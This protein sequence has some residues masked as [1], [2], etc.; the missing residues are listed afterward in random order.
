MSR[1]CRKHGRDQKSAQNFSLG[2]IRGRMG[3]NIKV[4][5]EQPQSLQL[6][7]ITDPLMSLLPHLRKET[8]PLSETFCSFYNTG[9]WAKSK[10]PIILSENIPWSTKNKYN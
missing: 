7:S 6:T 4:D 8:N 9:R 5:S 2:I 3:H 1:A 10:N